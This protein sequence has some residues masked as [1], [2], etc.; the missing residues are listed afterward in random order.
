VTLNELKS[1]LKAS[2]VVSKTS[3]QSTAQDD[4]FKEVKGRKIHSSED[5][6]QKAKKSMA[7]VPTSAAV[8]PPPKA[9]VTLNFFALLRYTN[10][11]T[12]TTGAESTHPEE[13]APSKRGRPSPVVMTSTTPHSTPK[14]LKRP[15]Q[16]K[17]Q[18]PKYM[19]WNPYH[20][21]RNGGLFSHEVLP[22][23]K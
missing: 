14:G 4:G 6:S 10:M 2:D 19:T 8:K 21:K 9:V 12:Y 17:L 15:H 22:G 16:R 5:T 7:P 3:M 18:F 13:E 20:N 23:G 11:G 1:V